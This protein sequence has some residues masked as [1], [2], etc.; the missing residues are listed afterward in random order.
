MNYSI[1]DPTGN[2]T[3]I[4][5]A[6]TDE[7]SRAASA[8]EVMEIEPDVEQVGFL[9]PGSGEYDVELMM[10]GGEFCGNASMSAAALFALGDGMPKGEKRTFILKVSGNPDPV[11]VEL[12]A[13]TET[14]FKGKVS[15]PH[16]LEIRNIPILSGYE[17]RVPVVFMPGIVHAII[18]E[19]FGI[20]K[21]E[22][23]LPSICED[24]GAEAMGLMLIDDEF[25]RITPVVYVPEANTLVREHSCASGTAAVGA[26]L[27]SKNGKDVCVSFNEPGGTLTVSA[28]PDGSIYI[29]GKVS[30][31]KKV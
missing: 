26:Y 19:K 3:A 12:E 16:A 25:S 4:V 14:S 24:L 23:L 13:I 11:P 15:M 10:A 29:E 1:L 8:N 22:K 2:I 27:A 20:E 31:T 17:D 7:S 9:L 21:A 30:L 18:P 28:S 6:P 5:T